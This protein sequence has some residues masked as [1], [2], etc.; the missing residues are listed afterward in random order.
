MRWKR[1]CH[2][3]SF[4]L[5]NTVAITANDIFKD[6][7]YNNWQIGVIGSGTVFC[8]MPGPL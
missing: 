2:C 1:A 4:G 7:G 5:L 3:L 8:G 6:F